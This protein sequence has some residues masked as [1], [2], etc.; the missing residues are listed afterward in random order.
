MAKDNENGQW[1][2]MQSRIE[3][4]LKKI[5]EKVT[6]G[7]IVVPVTRVQRDDT[8]EAEILLWGPLA[9]FEMVAAD[10]DSGKSVLQ[11]IHEFKAGQRILV[12]K[13]NVLTYM[14][15]NGIVHSFIKDPSHIVAIW[16]N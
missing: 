4:K 6:A 16:K 9:G 12:N 5:E 1:H 13:A 14:D 2:P 8:V 15:P 11:K 3:I 7:G 10:K